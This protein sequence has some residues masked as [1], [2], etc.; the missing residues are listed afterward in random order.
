MIW[1]PGKSKGSVSKL[2]ASTAEGGGPG[3]GAM[4]FAEALEQDCTEH[5]T[6]PGLPRNP[7]GGKGAPAS[8]NHTHAA[9]VMGK[10]ILTSGSNIGSC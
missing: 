1:A 2:G 5:N 9:L 8:Y 4:V 3:P 10:E 6:R 7:K